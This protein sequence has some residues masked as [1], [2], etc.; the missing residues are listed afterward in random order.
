MNVLMIRQPG[1]KNDVSLTRQGETLM[2][3]TP[4]DAPPVIFD[5]AGDRGGIVVTDKTILTLFEGKNSIVSLL[6]LTFGA[7]LTPAGVATMYGPRPFSIAIPYAN[8]TLDDCVV[9]LIVGPEGIAT[10]N[11]SPVTDECQPNTVRESLPTLSG[12]VS[13]IDGKCHLTVQLQRYGADVE[14]A[15]VAVYAETTVGYLEQERALTDSTGRCSFVVRS[16]A[17]GV[18]GKVKA[19]FRW[20]SGEVDLPISF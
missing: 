9:C 17:T 10:Y 11:G 8:A 13:M 6:P 18:A 1:I 16:D 14:R 12:S 15:G 3:S 2:I 20:Y 5:M 4:P 19:G 7:K